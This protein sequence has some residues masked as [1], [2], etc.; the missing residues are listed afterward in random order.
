M[1]GIAA[2]LGGATRGRE[3]LAHLRTLCDVQAVYAVNDAAAEYPG[4][5][6]AFVTLHPEKL[7]PGTLSN[8]SPSP[9]WL[10]IRNRVDNLHKTCEVIAHEPH[11]RV[12]RVV[13]YRWLGMNASGSS[14]LF[15]TKVALESQPYP[16]V[17][18]GVPM[19]AMRAH[20]FNSAPWWEVDSF[21]QAWTIAL[22]YIKDRVR[23]MSGATAQLLGM[24]TREFLHP[25]GG[26]PVLAAGR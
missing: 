11:P 5:L 12:T 1:T 26:T 25:A 16:V 15:A 3:E 14:G 4:D 17:L 9:D 22:P 2:V 6:T 7:G 23:S 13:D 10:S 19:D 21:W 20:Y 18:C 24:P 8:G